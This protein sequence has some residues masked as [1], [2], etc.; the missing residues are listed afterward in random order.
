MRTPEDAMRELAEYV[1]R[2]PDHAP[3]LSE[4]YHLYQQYGIA[5]SS[6]RLRGNGVVEYGTNAGSEADA[7][8]DALG[9][10]HVPA[11]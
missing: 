11:V 8:T 4:R 10:C 7:L 9:V 3:V 2:Q 1:W 5:M 6:L